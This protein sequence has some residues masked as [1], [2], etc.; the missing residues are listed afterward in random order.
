MGKLKVVP[1]KASAVDAT[2]WPEMHWLTGDEKRTG[3]SLAL[4]R[5]ARDN[6]WYVT[7][8]YMPHEEIIAGPYGSKEAFEML[9]QMG[10]IDL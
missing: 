4:R 5:A 2:V 10:V 9:L 6:Q 1:A 3:G 8:D 7:R